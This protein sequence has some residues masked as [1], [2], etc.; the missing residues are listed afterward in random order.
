MLMKKSGCEIGKGLPMSEF[1]I[2]MYPLWNVEKAEVS[3][4][5]A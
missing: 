4:I 1:F 3:A 5:S 2:N